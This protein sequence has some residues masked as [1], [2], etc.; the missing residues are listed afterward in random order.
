MRKTLGSLLTDS[1]FRM[2]HTS[3]VCQFKATRDLILLKTISRRCLLIGV[4]CPLIPYI[5]TL[6]V[7]D[8]TGKTQLPKRRLSQTLVREAVAH[9]HLNNPGVVK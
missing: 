4:T 6:W 1:Y 8:P 7:A 9:P 5:T 2:P 3:T